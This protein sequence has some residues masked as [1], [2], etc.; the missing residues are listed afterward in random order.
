MIL[1]HS[2]QFPLLFN[3]N[4]KLFFAFFSC[5]SIEMT[6]SI[7]FP[8]FSFTRTQKNHFL[9]HLSSHVCVCV[10]VLRERGLSRLFI[11]C[12]LLKE[13][14]NRQSTTNN[15][16]LECVACY[17]FRL[18]ATTHHNFNISIVHFPF[19]P[20]STRS[21][22]FIQNA[23]S[24]SLVDNVFGNRKIS[25]ITT[26]SPSARAKEC[27]FCSFCSWMVVGTRLA[28][29]HFQQT[30]KSEFF[31]QNRKRFFSCVFIEIKR[32]KKRC[33]TF[34]GR[35]KESERERKNHAVINFR[36]FNMFCC[37]HKSWSLKKD[38]LNVAKKRA[39]FGFV[40]R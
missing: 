26:A 2:E 40:R 19:H 22:G 11:F 8:Q 31:G 24:S 27:R 30:W 25:K 37:I 6:S 38:K 28:H 21:F 33:T 39:F 1:H 36:Q 29:A 18:N 20:C 32:G 3:K 16:T 35:R 13:K 23:W 10:C 12:K 5:N 7:F 4:R 34:V 9:R 15:L 17:R 14:K